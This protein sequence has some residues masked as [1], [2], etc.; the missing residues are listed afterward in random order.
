VFEDFQSYGVSQRQYCIAKDIK[1]AMR[2][3]FQA[4]NKVWK[5]WLFSGSTRGADASSFFFILINSATDNG[6]N[7]FDYLLHV[8]NNIRQCNSNDELIALLPHRCQ[9]KK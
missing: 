8:F 6:L 3:A 7:A 5:S 2:S 9:L 1:L 4:V